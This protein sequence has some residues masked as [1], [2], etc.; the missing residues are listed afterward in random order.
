MKKSEKIE[1]RVS[2]EEKEQLTRLAESEGRNVSELVRGLASKYAQL[3]ISRPRPK[4]SPLMVCAL[5]AA[6]LCMG[7]GAT[8]LNIQRHASGASPVNY[9]VHGV[10]EDHGFGFALDD[11][12]QA[13]ALGSGD[14]SYQLNAQF[15][16]DMPGAAKFELCEVMGD[17]CHA[18]ADVTLDT[19]GGQASSVWQAKTRTGENV[20]VVL[21]PVSS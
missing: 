4:S 3:N 14:G 18:F 7:A 19:D 21:Q 10:V 20:F 16:A 1:I 12:T 17:E 2:L 13:I 8:F 6:G 5:V 15:A 9:M 11:K